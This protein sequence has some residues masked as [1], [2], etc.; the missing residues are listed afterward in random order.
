MA[1]KL[2][3]DGHSGSEG[4]REVEVAISQDSEYEKKLVR[5]LDRNIVPVVMTLYLLSFLDRL[6]FFLPLGIA[7][8]EY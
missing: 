4:E 2:N 5:K 6:A 8:I 7:V 1:E 3:T